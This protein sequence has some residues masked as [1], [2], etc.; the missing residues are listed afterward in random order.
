MEIRRG[1]IFYI[2]KKN[3]TTGSEQWS[4]RPAVIVSNDRGNATSGTVEVVY[5]TTKDKKTMPTHVLIHSATKP[6][7]VLC[8]QICTVDVERIQNRCGRV[9]PEE[10]TQIERCL[11]VSLGMEREKETEK[12]PHEEA[13]I[14]KGK[15]EMLQEMYNKFLE[16]AVG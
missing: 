13:D 4:G 12:V 15:F 3:D 2:E 7:T 9:T 8:E 10:M 6:S 1:D 5:M 11:L 14:W 16:L